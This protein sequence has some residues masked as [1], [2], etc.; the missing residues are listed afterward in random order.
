MPTE[1][2]AMAERVWRHGQH[3]AEL[4][5]WSVR[6]VTDTE[7]LFLNVC[8]SHLR[9]WRLSSTMIVEVACVRLESQGLSRKPHASLHDAP[10]EQRQASLRFTLTRGIRILSRV[11]KS[12]FQLLED[13]EDPSLVYYIGRWR[14]L[15]AYTSFRAS[16][17]RKELMTA[18]Q[19][20]DASLEWHEISE[21]EYSQP[22]SITCTLLHRPTDIFSS[23]LVGIARCHAGNGW[24]TGG[25]AEV[26]WVLSSTRRRPV[27]KSLIGRVPL[28][29]FGK[30]VMLP[31]SSGEGG[32]VS[33][34]TCTVI[35]E[36]KAG[37][38]K[39]VLEGNGCQVRCSSI[40]LRIA[41]P[42]HL[43]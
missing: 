20:C 18:L 35:G 34:R 19:C 16:A 38:Q 12:T 1:Q 5:K 33:D 22:R 28:M 24:K 23:P 7:Y 30:D 29:K 41:S 4:H 9:T 39:V 2:H 31:S 15:A 37:K 14:S 8:C 25:G 21:A 42:V 13:I 17:E 3:R 26:E 43:R 36:W 27:H 11:S 10:Y 6:V 40:D 32:K